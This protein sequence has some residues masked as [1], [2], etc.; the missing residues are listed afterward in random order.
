VPL[1]PGLIPVGAKIGAVLAP[2]SP[3]L[4]HGAKW[5]MRLA[6]FVRREAARL[7]ERNPELSRKL[8]RRS[9]MLFVGAAA[10]GCFVG[11]TSLDYVDYGDER[12]YRLMTYSPETQ[13]E[14]GRSEAEH[15]LEGAYK[16]VVLPTDHPLT[17]TMWRIAHRLIDAIEPGQEQVP[18]PDWKIHVIADT[19]RNAFALPSGDIFVHLGMIETAGDEDCLAAVLGHEIAHVIARHGIEKLSRNDMISIPMS[20]LYSLQLS[21]GILSAIPYIMIENSLISICLR[22]P[23]SRVMETEA[24]ILGCRLMHRAGYDPYQAVTLWKRM[25]HMQYEDNPKLNPAVQ[26]S[27]EFL[28]THPTENTRI[29]KLNELCVDLQPAGPQKRIHALSETRKKLN[30]FKRFIGTRGQEDYTIEEWADFLHPR[31]AKVR[32]RVKKEQGEKGTTTTDGNT[33]SFS[34]LETAKKSEP[35]C[36][37]PHYPPH[38]NRARKIAFVN[39]AS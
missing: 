16:D 17:C 23:N 12:R 31:L 5:G 36:T 37:H 29:K 28:S 33:T 20:F 2:Y 13:A 11:A 38:E 4:T 14:V 25:N 24:D 1:F 7:R 18:K 32:E 30:G 9:R 3:A 34:S 10:T 8:Y 26:D 19:T 21:W 39:L 27:L 6:P 22:L 15:L 35:G